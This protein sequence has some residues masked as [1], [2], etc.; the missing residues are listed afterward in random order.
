MEVGLWF[1]LV[2]MKILDMDIEVLKDRFRNGGLGPRI[3]ERGLQEL[4]DLV[5]GEYNN[6][7][8]YRRFARAAAKYEE[9]LC[10]IEELDGKKSRFGFI[11]YTRPCRYEYGILLK[12]VEVTR[13]EDLVEVR[14]VSSIN[15]HCDYKGTDADGIRMVSA[16]SM[17]LEYI[18][19]EVNG[20]GDCSE[21]DERY[22]ELVEILDEITKNMRLRADKRRLKRLRKED[23]RGGE[24]NI[25]L[26]SLPE[27]YRDELNC[28]GSW[29]LVPAR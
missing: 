4:K 14:M 28:Y 12:G 25:S 10:F 15:P 24:K 5:K 17:G 9:L 16:K 21:C 23:D 7:P 19:A 11:S 26:V 13:M 20:N 22:G 1:L 29:P 3:L 8:V 27:D 18:W 2:E 6:E